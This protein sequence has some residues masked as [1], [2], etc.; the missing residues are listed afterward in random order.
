MLSYINLKL[1]PKFKDIERPYK[2][3]LSYPGA[4]FAII[5][6]IAIIVSFIAFDSTGF[7][8]WGVI[9]AIIIFILLGIEFK[10]Y[11]IQRLKRHEGLQSSKNVSSSEVEMAS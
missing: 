8:I 7:A 6:S 9:G 11:G 1:N 2:S 3:P 5:I 4:I 10:C